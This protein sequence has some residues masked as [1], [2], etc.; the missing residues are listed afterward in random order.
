L[1][2]KVGPGGDS[3]CSFIGAERTLKT[4]MVAGALSVL[5]DAE[6]QGDE[7]DRKQPD[8]NVVEWIK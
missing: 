7:P 2:E 1:F 5:C 6:N 8:P 3:V 4:V